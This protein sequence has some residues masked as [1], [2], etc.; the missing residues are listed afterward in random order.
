V[1][2]IKGG[3]TEVVHVGNGEVSPIPWAEASWL[4][5]WAS[6]YYND[7]HR[8]FSKKARKWHDDNIALEA[9]ELEQ[10]EKYPP[11]ELYAK[12]GKEGLLVGLMGVGQHL[13]GHTIFD[14]KGE[15]FDYFHEMILLE[16][17]PRLGVRGV[18]DGLFGG[19]MIG[20][21]AVLKFGAAPVHKQAAKEVLGG[22]KRICLCI[23]EP[24]VGSDVAGLKCTAT[25][26]PDGKHYIV[27]GVKKWITGGYFADYF[28]TAV[29]TGDE[30]IGGISML[31]IPR[32][33]GVETK[34]IKTSYSAAAGT[35]LVIFEVRSSVCFLVFHRHCPL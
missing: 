32:S 26:T 10:S 1:G 2:T 24:Y 11:L 34:A 18:S 21:P 12:G 17:V 19:L 29:R 23:S 13:H 8:E 28:T 6:P 33:E 3:K 15:E 14:V 35:S 25:K 30:G 16:N 31:L 22:E 7:S 9:Q 20:L 5:G 4:Q 27:N